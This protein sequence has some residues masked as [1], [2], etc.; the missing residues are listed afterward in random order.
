MGIC[1]LN[2]KR[3]HWRI[4]KCIESHF[5]QMNSNV[6]SFVRVLAVLPELRNC[7]S[8]MSLNCTVQ[9]KNIDNNLLNADNIRGNLTTAGEMSVK[10][11]P[12]FTLLIQ[13]G[14]HV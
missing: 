2:T 5:L 9:Q 13:Y 7:S 3:K 11:R 6:T 14:C 8:K 10:C 12:T 4:H 1:I